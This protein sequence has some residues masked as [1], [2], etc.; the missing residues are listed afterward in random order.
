[1]IPAAQRRWWTAAQR[2]DP[3]FDGVF[4]FGVHS[5]GI[6]CRPTCPARRPH[7]RQVVLYS[8]PRSAEREGFRPCK[9]CHPRTATRP[10]P[11]ARLAILACAYLGRHLE[12]RITLARMA[13]NLSVSPFHLQRMFKRALGIS[14]LEYLGVLRFERFKKRT[15]EGTGVAAALHEAGFSSPSRLYERSGSRLGM[16]PATFGKGGAGMSIAF[17]VVGCP[18]GRALLAT[19]PVG[20]CA[21]EFGD[22][23]RVLVG[24]LR[25]RYPRARIQRKPGPLRPAA[26]ELRRAFRG[27]APDPSIPLDVR[28]TAFQA[29]VWRELRLI[30]PGGT[31]S[32]GQIARRL[33]R[34]G[35]ARAVARACASNPVAVLV[36]CHR[37]IAASGALAGY[38]WGVERKKALL[39]RERDA[40]APSRGL[41]PGE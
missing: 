25:A 2:R 8:A 37:A 10:R 14:P 40:A 22:S 36:P 1:M 11:E 27:Q 16:T 26:R 13:R 24:R 31:R 23:D 32:Y 34:P 15:S 33:G 41:R 21:V 39:A 4:V 35:S 9:R 38:R 19:T 18:L 3:K 17:T 12:E 30:P 6:Y 28:A 5:T 29:R 7:E 20:L